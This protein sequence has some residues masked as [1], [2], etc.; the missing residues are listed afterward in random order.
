MKIGVLPQ[1][2]SKIT[3]LYP[4]GLRR[5]AHEGIK[6][7][8]YD[9]DEFN[10]TNGSSY[11]TGLFLS[12]GHLRNN[13]SNL[14]FTY[15][16]GSTN[17]FQGY[18]YPQL[19]QKYSP[20]FKHKKRT[21]LTYLVKSKKNKW[22]FKT[23]VS[24][25]SPIFA[26]FLEKNKVISKKF[27]NKTSGYQKNIS[28]LLIN[29]VNDRGA[30]FQGIFDGDG[31]VK[32]TEKNSIAL[33][34]AIE[35][36]FKHNLLINNFDLV[37]TLCRNSKHESLIYNSRMKNLEEIRFA[38]TSLSKL[39]KKYTAKD[40]A[41]QLNFMVDAAHNSIR[42]DKVHQL[43][44]IIKRICSKNYGEY[45][46]CLEIQRKI[47]RELNK[48]EIIEKVKSLEKRYPIKDNKYMPFIPNWSKE[49][50]SKSVWLDEAWTFFLNLEN[51]DLKR[52]SKKIDFREGVPINFKL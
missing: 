39:S 23:N 21:S 25:F 40:I 3:G 5:Y 41:K 18:W 19:I 13:G 1:T 45:R 16:C 7:L 38:P 29:S 34:L 28:K 35:H 24:S 33:S 31:H 47:R 14:S 30:F 20:I 36:L 43:I 4:R 46:H 9:D 32:I 48:L 11:F 37:P 27:A 15:Q 50:G 44:K 22:W 49:I 10:F 17:F 42:P 12:D 2:L 8:L 26:K 52:Y 6:P 51:L